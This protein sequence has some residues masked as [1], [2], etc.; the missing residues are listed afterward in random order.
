MTH[1]EFWAK[2]RAAG[3]WQVNEYGSVRTIAR[4]SRCPLGAVDPEGMHIPA[5]GRV[6]RQIA[7]P[8]QA[9]NHIAAAADQPES[10]YRPLLLRALGLA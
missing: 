10:D 7:I 6:A 1:D 5:V 4:P 8:L 3:E 2:V 9:A